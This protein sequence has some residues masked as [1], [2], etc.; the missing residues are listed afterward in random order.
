MGTPARSP[1][2][3]DISDIDRDSLHILPLSI[4]PVE[5][6]ALRR[7]RLIKNVRLQSV[8]EFFEE[9]HTGSGQLEIMAVGKEFDWPTDKPAADLTLLMKLA[10]MTSYDVYSLRIHL[11]EQGLMVNSID[12][13]KLSRAKSTELAEYMKVFSRPLIFQIYGGDMEIKEFDDVLSLFRDPDVRKAREKLGLMAKKLDIRVS[14]VPKFLEEYG[15]IFL[16]LSY[17]RQCLDQ[18]E[19]VISDL[20][21]TLEDLRGNWHLRNDRTLM[22]ACD[23]I[24][25][26]INEVMVA[27]TGHFENFDRATEA[28]WDNVSAESFRKVNK[29]IESYHTT[30]GGML[31][32]LSVKMHAWARLFPDQDTGGPA[33]RGEFIMTSI[34]QGIE[35]SVPKTHPERSRFFREASLR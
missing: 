35:N 10:E 19:P 20:L 21:E 28:M 25:N 2:P 22:Q 12:S 24:E 11:R 34:K 15:D 14:E 18:I 26:T 6:P 3:N 30:I 4:L 27:I 29:L 32:A 17:Y 5:T 9:K 31:C 7:A 23:L 33:R 1:A 16:S 8:V 13:L